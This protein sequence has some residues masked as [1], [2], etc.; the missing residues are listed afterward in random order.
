MRRIN[1]DDFPIPNPMQERASAVS[2]PAIS[3]P[4][5]GI[6]SLKVPPHS[7]EAEQS[8]LGSLMLNNEAWLNVIDI[9]QADDF[10]RLE[11]RLLFEA[12]DG[13]W[14]DNRPIDAVTLAEALAEKGQLDRIGGGAFLADLAEN[15]P[16]VSNVVAYARIVRERSTQRQLIRAGQRIADSGFE[17]NGH[18]SDDLLNQA[19]SEVFSIAERRLVNE[20]PQP[21][22]PMLG[23]AVEELTRL[24]ENKGQLPGLSSGFDV[25]DAKT[26]GFK[27]SDLIV[28][29]GRPSMGKTALAMNIVEYA[30]IGCKTPSL[31]FSME[32]SSEQ[33]VMRLLSS[34]ARI[35][36]SDMQTGNLKDQDWDRFS[37]AVAHLRDQPLYIDDTP[38]LT[39]ASLRARV[40]RATREAGGRL[41]LI[42]VDYLQLMRPDRA[43]SD[44]RTQEISEISR[45]MKA[46]AKE[47][48]C[49][50][51]AL[52]QLNREVDKRMNK[53]PMMSDLRDSGA[54]EQ[55]ADLI[56]FIYRDEVY[57]EESMDK[58]VAEI[59]I[60]KQRN[61]VSGKTVRLSFLSSL[62]KFEELAPD[63]Y[64]DYGPP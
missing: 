6:R 16:G 50:L 54:I 44:N 49:P 51:I 47:M 29:A 27:N 63:R 41:G 45:S 20:G 60:G 13:L 23:K 17:P 56:I 36:Q 28:I 12:M 24:Y 19:E 52:S 38:A 3:N 21:V 48:K 61:G 58:G 14:R 42:V 39:P 34:L 11:H 59:I 15:T 4:P 22:T 57:N 18:S 9:V 33:L 1:S 55:D 64:D 25:L 53:R 30:V 31:V 37:S 40:R 43:R 32:M 8:V 2:E 26:T 5:D 62:T 35:G 7:V 10:Y 46:I